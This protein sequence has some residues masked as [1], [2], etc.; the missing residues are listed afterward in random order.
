MPQVGGAA[1][2]DRAARLR[3][4][5]D[6]A[7]SSHLQAQLGRAHH[8]LMESQRMGRTAQFAEVVFDSDQPTGQIVT[9]CV[10]GHNATQLM[11]RPA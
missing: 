8:V 3:A 9:A 10:T 4:V 11:A 6:A 5:G 2:K 7:A 1:I